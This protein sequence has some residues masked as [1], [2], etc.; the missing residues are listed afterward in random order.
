MT[1][2]STI[3]KV[4]QTLSLCNRENIHATGSSKNH[5]L[6]NFQCQANSEWGY[7]Q[8][9]F[10]FLFFQHHGHHERFLAPDFLYSSLF[11]L[12]FFFSLLSHFP[13]S[14][15]FL[16][17]QWWSSG[18]SH[19]HAEHRLGPQFSHL[20]RTGRHSGFLCRS[21]PGQLSSLLP[22]FSRTAP[23]HAVN[24]QWGSGAAI[25]VYMLPSQSLQ[26]L[27]SPA[28]DS[29]EVPHLGPSPQ[30]SQVPVGTPILLPSAPTSH[31]C[32]PR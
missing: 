25:R 6:F 12:P 22:S 4:I 32:D 9:Y 5:Q 13:F 21:G 11:S 27:P 24:Q 2:I 30:S 19:L 29:A 23:C 7:S 31:P 3:S 28:A 20:G 17:G 8:L 26:T 18:P 16:Q 15:C 14:L 1:D 10:P